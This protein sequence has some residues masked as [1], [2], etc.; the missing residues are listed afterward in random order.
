VSILNRRLH[1]EGAG[2][3][4]VASIPVYIPYQLWHLTLL[5][6]YDRQLRLVEETSLQLVE[7][8]VTDRHGLAELLGLEGDEA[9]RQVLIDLLR[10]TYLTYQ[11]ER[12]ALTPLGRQVLMNARARVN[13]R[14]G[15]VAVLYDPFKDELGWYGEQKLL[16]GQTVRESGIKQLPEFAKLDMDGISARHQS[17]QELIERKGIPGDPSPEVKKDLLL[18]EPVYWENVYK[19]ADLELWQGEAP[20]PFDWRLL[21]VDLELLDETRAYKQLEDEGVRIIP[22]VDSEI[23]PSAPLPE[24][25]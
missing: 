6:E 15:G 4:P 11:Q 22:K 18:I 7:A 21:Q 16:T 5:V 24:A 17:V 9:F 12:L 8:G 25:P 10:G 3:K 2:Y 19:R 13:R 1:L 14:F 23:R 20:R